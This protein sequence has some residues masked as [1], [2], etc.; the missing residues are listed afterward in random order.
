MSRGRIPVMVVAVILMAALVLAV[1]ISTDSPAAPT[2]PAFA[3]TNPD[4]IAN[5]TALPAATPLAGEAGALLVDLQSQVR[6]CNDLSGARRDQVQQHIDWLQQPTTIPPDIALALSLAGRGITGQL[7]N[8]MAIYTSTEWRLLD[9]PPDSC[10]I[11]IGRTL[12]AMLV[13]VG[14]T[15][16]TI[17]DE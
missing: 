15:A 8:G 10:L 14:E 11:A 4:V 5:L 6:S 12:N 7:I 13:A 2:P 3:T 17:Y 16:L 9:R 1:F